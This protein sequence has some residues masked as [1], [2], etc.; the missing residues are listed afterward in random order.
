V[1]TSKQATKVPIVTFDYT[2]TEPEGTR[3]ARYDELHAQ[4]PWYRNEFGPSFWTVC[5]YQGILQIMQHAQIP[6]YRLAPDAQMLES[7]SQL[8]LE[9]LPLVWGA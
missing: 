2:T 9:S 8:G 1:T 6:D 4:F 3:F 5:N 7:G